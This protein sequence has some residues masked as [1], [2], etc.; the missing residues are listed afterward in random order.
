ME[1][2]YQINFKDVKSHESILGYCSHMI[3]HYKNYPKTPIILN[4]LECNFI[5]PDYALLFMCA[6]K[7]LEN[8]GIE[9][10]GNIK[11]S[12][13]NTDVIDYL[14]RMNFFKY[15]KVKIPRRLEQLKSNR[16]VEIQKYNEVNQL[17]VLNSII[18]II[19]ENTCI[20]D[21]VITSLDYCLNEILDNVLNHSENKEGWVVAQYFYKINSIRLIVADSGIGIQKSLNTKHNFTEDEAIKKCIEQGVTNGKGQGHGLYATSTFTKL[22]KGWLSLISGIKKL[23]ISEGDS[24]IKDIPFWQG[25]CVYLRVNTNVDVDYKKFTSEHFDY[26]ES[27]FKEMFK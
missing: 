10:H 7:H 19:K 18:N 11:F 3:S 6:F 12:K 25:T 5:Y 26:K 15:L 21:N 1:K 24:K 8:C 14:A 23:D 17:D 4:F 9:I 16:F 2:P 13:D 27:V 22:N 20:N